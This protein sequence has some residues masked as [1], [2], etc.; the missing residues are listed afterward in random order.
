M[1]KWLALGLLATGANAQCADIAPDG[2]PDGRVDVNGAQ[3][4]PVA[5]PR[6]LFSTPEPYM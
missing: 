5:D 2:A 6:S 4:T 3:N 1:M